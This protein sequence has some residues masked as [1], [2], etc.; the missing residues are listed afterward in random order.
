LIVCCYFRSAAVKVMTLQHFPEAGSGG[1]VPRCRVETVG[2]G[3]GSSE[4]QCFSRKQLFR[5]LAALL[6]TA[7]GSPFY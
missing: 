7:Q 4:R 3:K 1:L 2:G 5:F 6:T